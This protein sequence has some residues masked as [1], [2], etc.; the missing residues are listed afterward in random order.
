MGGSM[1]QI[2]AGRYSA[3]L[4]RPFVVFLIGMRVNRLFAFR[5]WL[6]IPAA[7]VKMLN[8]LRAHPES[9]MLH[10]EQFFRLWPLT[11]I[12]VSYWRSFDDLEHF[13]RSTS[14]PH[15]ATWQAFA[16]S[17]GDDGSVGIW[18]ETYA[19]EPGKYEVIHVN[20]PL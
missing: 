20:M 7:F 12:M 8:A 15:L 17:V 4:D 6:P 5:K 2:N 13:A 3:E 14:E 9:G 11:T 10:G 1:A 19:V 16:R 18:H